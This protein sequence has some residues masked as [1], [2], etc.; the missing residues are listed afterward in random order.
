MR[1]RSQKEKQSQDQTWNIGYGRWTLAPMGQTKTQQF[2]LL[3]SWT[4]TT[5]FYQTA[6][7]ESTKNVTFT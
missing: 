3:I 1:Y 5:T 4:Q 6:A 7:A 2:A